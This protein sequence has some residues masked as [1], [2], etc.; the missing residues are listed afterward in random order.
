[1]IAMSITERL[2][3]ASAGRPWLVIGAWVVLVAGGAYFALGISDVLTTDFN[4][5]NRPESALADDLIEERMRGPERAEEFVIVQSDTLTVD[6]KAFRNH[7]GLLVVTLALLDETVESVTSYYDVHSETMVSAD[8]HKTI[9]PI[10]LKGKAG[11]ASD[12]VGPI[13]EVVDEA[14]ERIDFDVLTVGSGSI[15]RFFNEQSEKDLQRGEMIGIP[16][17]LII[18]V[19]VFGALVAA[20]VPLLLAITS[21]VIAV[22]TTALVGRAFE[23]NFFVVN[24]ITMVGLAVGIDYSLFVIH[25]YREERSRGFEKLDAIGR[26]GAT[27]GRAVLYSG[28]AVIV[29]LAGMLIVPIN[30]YRSLSVGAIAVAA[31]AVMAALTLLP[32]MLSILGDKINA[33]RIPLLQTHVGQSSEGGLWHRI[34]TTVMQHPAVSLV[35]S[36]GLLIA[37][38]VPYLSINPGL[39]GVTSLPADS[40][41]RQA[42]ETLD[43]EFS[44]GLLSP[45]EIAIDAPD[46]RAPVVL[47]AIERLLISIRNDDQ[48]Q[49]ATYETNSAGDLTVISAFIKGDTESQAAH[50]AVSTLR[51]EYVPAA[52]DGVDG[53]ALVTGA[54]ASEQDM[55]N[56]IATY[57][58]IVFAFVL[59]LSF[60]L[61]LLVFR[62]IVVPLKALIMNLLSVGAA[63]G[64]LVLVFQHGIGNEVFGFQQ[65]DV[66]A[67]WLPLFLFAFLFGLSMDYHVFLLSRIKERYDETGDNTASVAYGL[68]STAGLITGAAL[69]MVAV[70]SGFAM[71][72]LVELQQ[73]GFGLGVAVL[74]DATIVRSIL[75][76]ASMVLLGD[77]NWYLPNWLQWLPA[78]QLEERPVDAGAP[79]LE[80]R[81]TT[82]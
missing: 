38:A 66:I 16:I 68:T 25:R 19:I 43:S 31:F 24:M 4:L 82:E 11:D 27:A 52:F 3:R 34:A 12:N 44:S 54:T 29:G 47:V 74:I 21:I 36:A 81:I 41:V 64:L 5:T 9:I 73:M 33:G 32:A 65:S 58:P 69:I 42:F 26:T 35:A 48:F 75:V 14:N 6:D 39:V 60:V 57:T 13:M 10:V 15:E 56:T 18:L 78:L 20:G 45:A 30:I 51:D 1:M 62:S 46:V 7:V 70:F 79:P 71:G 23:L 67:A 80:A 77:W 55:F 17:A 28:A 8:R 76:P 50:D 37:L 40:D 2:A 53:R 63:Y 61:L 72:D 49:G 59:G 22:G